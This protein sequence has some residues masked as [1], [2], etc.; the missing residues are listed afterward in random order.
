MPDTMD[1][2]IYLWVIE[3]FEW[4]EPVACGAVRSFA[5]RFTLYLR[6]V[7]SVTD[8]PALSDAAAAVS[9]L[10]GP[11]RLIPEN[12]RPVQ[13]RKD[14]AGCRIHRGNATSGAVRSELDRF[15]PDEDLPSL[16]KCG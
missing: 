8:W 3:A 10:R 1:P 2:P 7:P 4:E 6:R 9:R 14:F 15:P 5:D 16:V 12:D 13:F 11:C